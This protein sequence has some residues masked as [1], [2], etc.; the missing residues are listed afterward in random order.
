MVVYHCCARGCRTRRETK[1]SATGSLPWV[2]C[3]HPNERILAAFSPRPASRVFLLLFIY[4][5]ISSYTAHPFFYS[6][7][8]KL[9]PVLGTI[10]HS[11][12]Y[13]RRAAVGEHRG[14]AERQGSH[15]RG[16][17][18]WV[19]SA[20]Y[21]D[22]FAG[23]SMVTRG[24]TALQPRS[25]ARYRAGALQL[26]PMPTVQ[27]LLQRDGEFSQS[28]SSCRDFIASSPGRVTGLGVRKRCCTACPAASQLGAA[29]HTAGQSEARVC[30]TSLH[31]LS[32]IY[33]WRPKYRD[34]NEEITVL[35]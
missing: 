33:R 5:C 34:S 10:P 3:L 18:A 32:L 31:S 29:A 30:Y 1:C 25:R 16:S 27:T 2:H 22:T 35:S 19:A 7:S 23:D 24:S 26:H 12:H 28:K 13:L 9:I 20:E 14:A 17:A 21:T 6:W 4:F 15:G 8:S 11:K